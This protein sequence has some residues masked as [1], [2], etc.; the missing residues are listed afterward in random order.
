[1]TETNIK[2]MVKDGKMARFVYYRDNALWYET[3]CGFLFAIPLFVNGK[4]ADDSKSAT[5]NAEEKAI[6]LMRW[7]RKQV[8]SNE[9]ARS[10]QN[11]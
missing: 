6:R 10:D 11:S 1:M 4:V 3:D 2:D 8:A 7:I 5:F 9:E